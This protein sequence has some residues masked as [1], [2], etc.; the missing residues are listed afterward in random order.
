MTQRLGVA[1]ALVDGRLVVGD[2]SV[3]PVTGRIDQ[4]ALGGRGSGVAVPGLVD[5]QVNGVAGID[6]RTCGPEGWAEAALLLAAGGATAVQPTFHSQPLGSHV[7]SLH[8]LAEVITEPP[9]G[10]SFLPAHLEGPFLSRDWAGAHDIDALLPPHPE[11][12]REL[13]A[14]GP[15]GFVTL[16]PELPGA[17]ALIDDL[18]ASGV[19]VSVGHSD[20]TAVEVHAA[21]DRGARH[22]THCWNAHRRLTARD[23]GPAGVALARHEVTIGLV[24]DLVHVAAEV[25]RLTLAA[26]PGRVAITTD[27]VAATAGV[28]VEDGVARRADGTIAGG[29]ARPVDCLRNLVSIGVDLADAVDACGGA[30]RR[31]LGLPEVR[32][33]PGDTADV[34]VLDDR[35]EV[36]SLLI[37]GRDVLGY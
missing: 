31:L 5:L 15:V 14:A 37:G 9:R 1:A 11:V 33:R 25:V 36:E 22:L 19:V 18:V 32:L 7:S 4:V 12:L 21:I 23:P 2:V 34:L 16:A 27:S 26:A 24:G 28:A 20:A 8:E 3:D 13:L 29:V 30:Q 35:L 17:D 6:L 10:C